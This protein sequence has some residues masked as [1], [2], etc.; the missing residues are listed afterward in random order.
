MN[1][2]IRA[3]AMARGIKRLCHFTPS[4]NLVHIATQRQGVLATQHLREDEK[5]VLNP[6]DLERFDGYPDHVC[7]SIQ[8][9]NA[10]YFRK[11]EEKERLF[12]DWVVLLISAHYLWLPGTKFCP[13]NAAANYGRDVRSGA[14][15]FESLFAPS[16]E[17]AYGTI[18]RRS[19][20][21]PLWLPT[22]DQAEVLIPDRIRRED[23]L[24]IAVRDESQAKRETVRLEQLDEPVPPIF[25]APLFFS[26]RQLSESLRKGDLPAE[27]G[28]TLGGG[29]DA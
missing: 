5:T 17:G 28:Y 16:V 9:P 3:R 18:Y 25:I 6:T 29:D 13:R 11:A 19:G 14:E 23:I 15:A 1:E 8:Y 21:H 4:R 20:S 2:A 22:D 7:C 12:R 10:W 26:A 27:R 24:G